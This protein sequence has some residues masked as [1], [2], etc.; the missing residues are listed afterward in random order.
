MAAETAGP[1]FTVAALQANADR[2]TGA[3]DYAIAI[4]ANGLL[5][6]M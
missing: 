1:C 4:A 2:D 3:S 6:G 5:G